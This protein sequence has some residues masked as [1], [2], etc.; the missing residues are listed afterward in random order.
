MQLHKSRQGSLAWAVLPLVLV[1]VAAAA[2][3]PATAQRLRQTVKPLRIET[4]HGKDTVR[5]GDVETYRVTVNNP[6]DVEYRWTTSGRSAQGNPVVHRFERPGTFNVI[7]T[8]RNMVSTVSDT[9][10]VSVF[11]PE[12]PPVART[13]DPVPESA[14]A[15]KTADPAPGKPPP[16]PKTKVWTHKREVRIRH[17]LN[18]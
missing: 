10:V 15:T 11:G 9:M 8:A 5:V 12:P 4:I 6:R 3:R 14:G 17:K 2:W 13:M 18:Q 1:T 7:V 16:A